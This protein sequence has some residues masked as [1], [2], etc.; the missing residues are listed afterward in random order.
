M[1]DRDVLENA[2]SSRAEGEA[3]PVGHDL[4][5]DIAEV[6]IPE[7]QLQKRIQELGETITEDY[8]GRD[9]V[10]VGILKG[11][12]L[13]TAD[14]FRW[15]RVPASLDFMRIVSYAGTRT[16]GVH[17]VLLDLEYE[18]DGRDVL[19]VEDIVDTGLTLRFLRDY[20][21]PR[22]PASLRVAALLDKPSRRQVDVPIDYRG[23]EIPDRF[24]VGMGLDF[25]EKYRNLR[26]ICVLRPEV[27][28]AAGQE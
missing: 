17:R 13:F 11:A 2:A 23:F 21:L 16:T 24:V 3:A 10:V 5:E 4:W 19:V 20:L 9:L 15:I 28:A 7:D 12:A 14:L 6:L 18:L 27:Y 22:N 8:R 1:Y 26:A 25:N